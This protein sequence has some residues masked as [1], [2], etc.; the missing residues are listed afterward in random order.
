MASY[1]QLPEVF[2]RLHPKLQDAVA[3]RWSSSPASSRS[4]RC[5]RA[6]STSS[7]R[8][9]RSARCSRS[10]SRTSSVIALRVR[11]TGRGARV[12]AR[13]RTCALGGVDWPLFAVVGGLG[14]GVAWLVVVV[15]DAATRYAGLAWLALG[16]VVYA[17]YRRRVV[18][19]PLTRDGPGARRVRPGARARVPARA[20]PGRAGAGR[21]RR[22]STSR[23][24]SRRSAARAIVAL[25]RDR[26]AARPAAWRRAPFAEERD[27]TTSSTRRSRS[28]TRTA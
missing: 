26:G 13:G 8:C 12:H 1:R 21:R 14:T 19:E 15:P 20:R 18:R 5:C 23:A 17:V 6:R 24:A 2:R 10:R 4:C 9:T 22:R 28:A 16:F 3:R 7:G 25:T 27:A 11:R